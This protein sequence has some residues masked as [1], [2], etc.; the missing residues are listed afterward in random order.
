MELLFIGK[1]PFPKIES[2]AKAEV[3]Y[4]AVL[5]KF[6]VTSSNLLNRERLPAPKENLKQIDFP[7]D[8]RGYYIINNNIFG[9]YNLE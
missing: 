7:D 9:T 6:N 2:P 4:R 1:P 5:H 8:G 3:V